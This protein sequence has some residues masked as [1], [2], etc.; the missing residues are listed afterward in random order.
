[1]KGVINMI[2]HTTDYLNEPLKQ[3]HDMTYRDTLKP[4]HDKRNSETPCFANRNGKCI[5]LKDTK[6]NP[7]PFYKTIARVI[8]EDPMYYENLWG[9]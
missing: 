9:L 1:M 2:K 4:C 7:C 5:C 3:N 8:E 6:L